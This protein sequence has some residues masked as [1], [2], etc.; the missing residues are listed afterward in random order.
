MD[1]G[2]RQMNIHIDKF[3][4]LLYLPQS[5]PWTHLRS[6][7]TS[8]KNKKWQNL[9][10]FLSHTKDIL[11]SLNWFYISFLLCS[12]L[13]RFRVW[14]MLILFSPLNYV[15]LFPTLSDSSWYLFSYYYFGILCF[16]R[17][18][19]QYF[20]THMLFYNVT[21]PPF[22]QETE[23]NSLTLEYGWAC[24]WVD[25][26]WTWE[27]TPCDLWG[28]QKRNRVHLVLLGCVLWKGLGGTLK[29]NLLWW[30]SM[31]LGEGIRQIGLLTFT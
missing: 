18:L 1:P 14:F 31:N 19:Q 25:Q 27:V 15:T 3:Y 28:G 29:N 23:S 13:I 7:Y 20:S 12:V 2:P 6:L 30:K 24:D 8:T 22:Q 4:I 16:Q 11:I 10:M 17:P 9:M 5:F 26:Y 21:W